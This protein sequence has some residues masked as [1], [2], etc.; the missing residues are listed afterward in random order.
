M[1]SIIDMKLKEQKPEIF[2][3]P[4]VSKY[5]VMDFLKVEEI[6]SETENFKYEVQAALKAAIAQ[7]QNKAV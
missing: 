5:R 6:L 4:P 2:L 7:H 1:R 3:R